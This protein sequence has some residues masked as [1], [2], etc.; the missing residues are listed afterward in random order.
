MDGIRHPDSVLLPLG[1]AGPCGVRTTHGPEDPTDYWLKDSYVMM[2]FHTDF[3][4]ETHQGRERGM[5]GQMLINSPE[6]HHWHRGV[7]GKGYQ[8]DWIH[9]PAEVGR[10]Y[11]AGVELPMNEIF[12]V[13]RTD[14]FGDRTRSIMRERLENAPHSEEIASGLVREMILLSDRYRKWAQRIGSSP[15][16]QG[17]YRTL[18]QIRS[19]LH[20]EYLKDWGLEEM[21]KLAHLSTN[22]FSVLYKKFFNIAP[23][24]DLLSRRIELAKLLLVSGSWGVGEVAYKVGFSNPN[25][26]SRMFHARMGVTASAYVA[27]HAEG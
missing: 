8:N 3:E 18:C 6:F 17:H 16:E 26:F 7:D 21:A 15:T 1:A 23:F 2:I 14:Y 19:K 22:R 12:T 24:E 4:A 27:K 10:K 5:A 20:E 13:S 9:I 25:Y 11:L